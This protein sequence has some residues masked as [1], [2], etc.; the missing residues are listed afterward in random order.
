MAAGRTVTT[1]IAK[2][3]GSDRTTA[4][5]IDETIPPSGLITLVLVE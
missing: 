4:D 5:L 1:I 2:L 3:D